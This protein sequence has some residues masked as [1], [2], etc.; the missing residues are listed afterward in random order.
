MSHLLWQSL[1]MHSVG[2][3]CRAL[4]M[5]IMAAGRGEGRLLCGLI[6]KGECGQKPVFFTPPGM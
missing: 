1:P 2:Q 5:H 4:L 3:P 6:F